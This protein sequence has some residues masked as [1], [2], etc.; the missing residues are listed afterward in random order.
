MKQ[1]ISLFDA[2][3][4]LKTK[5]INFAVVISE[6]GKCQGII[7]LKQIFEKLVLKEFKDDDIQANI[8]WHKGIRMDPVM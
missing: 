5:K 7:T 8:H 3:D 1:N 6:S 2:I 4:Q